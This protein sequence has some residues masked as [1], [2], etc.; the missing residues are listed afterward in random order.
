MVKPSDLA[1]RP[2]VRVG[3]LSVSPSRR[4]IE[5]PGGEAQLEPVVMQVL[6]MLLDE[7]GQVVT[8]DELFEAGWGGAAVGD[9]SLN[10]AIN[11]I[12]RVLDEVAPGVL[13]VETIPR[14][15][16]R[17][18]GDRL[19]ARRQTDEPV[20]SGHT[21]SRR[22]IIG[23]AAAAAV[24]AGGAGLWL[25]HSR[26]DQQFRKLLS[27]GEWA[28]SYGDPSAKPWEYFR[29]A[30]AMRPH[31]ARAQGLLAYARAMRAEY[32]E[33]G[34]AGVALR[35]AEQAT[36][37]ALSLDP[38]EPNARLAQIV[39][40]RSSLDFATT[41]A[42]LRAVLAA[43]PNNT[44]TMRQ[45]WNLLQCV[46][47]SR[48]ALALTERAVAL[49]PLGAAH[50][51]PKAQLLW[52]VGRNAEADRVIDRAMLYWPEHRNVRFARFTILAFTGRARAALAMLE[53]KETA[54]QV[55]PPESVALWRVSLKALDDAS[56]ENVA[57]A[58]RAN[59]DAAKENPRLTSQAVM[60]LSALGDTD[61]A[62]AITDALFAISRTPDAQRTAPPSPP[63]VTSSAWRFAPWLF[64]PPVAPLRADERFGAL[65]DQSGLTDYWARRGIKPDYQLGL[66]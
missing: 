12:R 26:R 45:L 27:D 52:I 36:S 53:K 31:H 42:R 37:A 63:P 17:M 19:P 56:P 39:I 49:D 34:E 59:V 6:L 43:D 7:R 66:A 51:F 54:P 22:A 65:C 60:T 18:V 41:E 46:G 33:P 64:T 38:E 61:G 35:E 62:F 40:A 15:G 48:D 47:R 16:Y 13:Q 14:T 25:G 44:N 1:G 3:P 58:R 10:R 11:R 29:R 9:D 28:L 20:T 55:F 4:R 5:G 32:G 23:G 57:A 8:R 21:V 2:D 24:A 30:I 50:M